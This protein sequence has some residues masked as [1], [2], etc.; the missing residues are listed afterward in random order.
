[1]DF[2]SSD[3]LQHDEYWQLLHVTFKTTSQNSLSSS[4]QAKIKVFFPIFDFVFTFGLY[5]GFHWN[6][7]GRPCF[8]HVTMVAGWST[9]FILCLYHVVT[10]F[11]VTLLYDVFSISRGVKTTLWDEKAAQ[12]RTPI[13]YANVNCCWHILR[14]TVTTGVSLHVGNHVR[15]DS[16]EPSDEWGNVSNCQCTTKEI[17]KPLER[18]K[19]RHQRC[20]AHSLVGTPNYIAPE[21]LLRSGT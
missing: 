7:N 4:N 14:N 6:Q 11:A 19:L 1:M 12:T 5:R 10:C 9:D 17:L 18:R 8:C 2:L 16:M 15:Q 3:A 13:D 21:V 20:L